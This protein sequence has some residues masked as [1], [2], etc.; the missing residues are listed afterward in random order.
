MLHDLDATLAALLAAELSLPNV[1]VSFEGPDE[2]FPPSSV[3]LPAI[4]LFLYDIRENL[5]LRTSEWDL[6]RGQ[7]GATTRRRAP[8][9]V[10]C[11]YLITAWASAAAPDPAAD[12]HRLLGEVMAVLLRHRSIPDTYLQGALTGQE[13]P[14]RTRVM[15]DGQ[16]QSIGEFWQAMGGRPKATLHYGV[17]VSVDVFEPAALGPEVTEHVIRITRE[18]AH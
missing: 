2:Q 14:V 10:D 3:A 16:L 7:D 18:P 15:A 12:E 6:T 1:S 8:A 4:S 9:R 13:P 17:T 5:D 11:S